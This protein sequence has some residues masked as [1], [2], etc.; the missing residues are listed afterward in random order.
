MLVCLILFLII[1]VIYGVPMHEAELQV[2]K[3]VLIGGGLGGVCLLS[4]KYAPR[5]LGH[6]DEARLTVDRGHR[7]AGRPAAPPHGPSVS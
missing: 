2:L 3:D 6:K 7:I 1:F 4:V 5:L